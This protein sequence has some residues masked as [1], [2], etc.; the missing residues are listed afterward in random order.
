MSIQKKY[1]KIIKGLSDIASLKKD[2]DIDSV[3]KWRED[4]PNSL[5]VKEIFADK[6]KFNAEIAKIDKIK[7]K[8]SE[9]TNKLRLEIEKRSHK[10]RSLR[11]V[12]IGVASAILFLSVLIG[13]EY[14][15]RSNELQPFEDE[16][17]IT[18]NIDVPMIKLDN[19]EIITIDKAQRLKETEISLLD[20]KELITSDK[21]EEESKINKIIIPKM[22]ILTLVL[23][24]GTTIM[25]DANS[26]LEYPTSF[27]EEERWVRLS[28]NAFF[29]V[30]KSDVL[31][32]VYSQYGAVKVYGTEFNVTTNKDGNLAT[33]LVSGSVGVTPSNS[34]SEIMIKP[35]EK[36]VVEANG[37]ST[38]STVDVRKYVAWSEG[39]FKLYEDTVGELLDNISVWYGIQINNQSEELRNRRVTASIKR[40]DSLSEVIT[41]IEMATNRILINEGK[42]VYSIE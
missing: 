29:K 19:G 8:N 28:G 30:A 26:E 31:F 2:A 42:G 38:V 9:Y 5:F 18:E 41:V 15:S 10:K 36:I 24:D 12:Y 39:Y 1:T 37:N 7:S 33:V 21:R 3:D 23:D 20:L 40:D 6:E 17:M 11:R 27:S 14:V 32:K 25:L 4:E 16:L 34:R 13:Y 35:S 22:K